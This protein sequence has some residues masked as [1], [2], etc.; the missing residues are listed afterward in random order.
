M[1]YCIGTGQKNEGFHLLGYHVKIHHFHFSPFFKFMGGFE[2]CEIRGR[3]NRHRNQIAVERMMDLFAPRH[4]AFPKCSGF[5]F[6]QAHDQSLANE[7]LLC[8]HFNSRL[9]TQFLFMILKV[10]NGHSLKACSEWYRSTHAIISEKWKPDQQ[11]LI[12]DL[13]HFNAGGG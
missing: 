1:E 6:R 12:N 4:E 11:L 3:I 5:E 8:D 2:I 7:F 13:D 10:L 9:H